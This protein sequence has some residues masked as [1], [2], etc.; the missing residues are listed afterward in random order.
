MADGFGAALGKHAEWRKP[1]LS[2]TL[3]SQSSTTEL[4]ARESLLTPGASR[5][6]SQSAASQTSIRSTSTTGT[7]EGKSLAEVE[8]RYREESEMVRQA[9]A[10][11][12]E[13]P[14]FSIDAIGDS[15]GEDELGEDDGGV[16]DE[17]SDREQLITHIYSGLCL[18]VANALSRSRRSSK[19][20]ATMMRGSRESRRRLRRVGDDTM[21]GGSVLMVLSDLLN[22]EPM[23]A[24]KPRS[25]SQT[26]GQ[27]I[28][29]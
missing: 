7:A 17:V 25:N 1:A 5:A 9:Q 28:N 18:R 29:I 12:M 10:A 26:K 4:G 3:P 20:M 27:S 11:V 24:A 8:A 6:R 16:M 21:S 19:H 13:R 15:D 22:A 2:K 14:N 23:G